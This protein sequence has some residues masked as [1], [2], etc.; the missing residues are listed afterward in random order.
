M[1]LAGFLEIDSILEIKKKWLFE[2]RTH[3]GAMYWALAV[4][5]EASCSETTVRTEEVSILSSS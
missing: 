2:E 5:G 1:E 4:L 3:L